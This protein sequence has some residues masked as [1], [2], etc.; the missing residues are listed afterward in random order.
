VKKYYYAHN[1]EPIGP[2]SVEELLTYPVKPETLIW[3][4]GLKDWT[5]AKDLPEFKFNPPKK[6]RPILTKSYKTALIGLL[7]LIC[8][9]VAIG[10]IVK[11]GKRRSNSS[12]REW[13]EDEL[14]AARIA[15]SMIEVMERGTYK[16]EAELE[17]EREIERDRSRAEAEA[18]RISDSMMQAMEAENTAA[19]EAVYEETLTRQY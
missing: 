5:P 7:L 17:N 14:E 8:F 4:E 16:D 9:V 11:P 3:H 1:T 12:N 10:L 6:N 2:F 19:E 15:D 13:T 18:Q